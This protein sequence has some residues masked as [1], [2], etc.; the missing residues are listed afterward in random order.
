MVLI[1]LFFNL[2]SFELNR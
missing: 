1:I 2:L